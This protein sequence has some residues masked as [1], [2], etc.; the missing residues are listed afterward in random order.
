MGF[1]PSRT[2]Y[3][4][5][6]VGFA[7]AAVVLFAPGSLEDGWTIRVAMVVLAAA[8]SLGS[9]V[10]ACHVVLLALI[11]L[12]GGR[13]VTTNEPVA[14]DRSFFGVYRVT[15]RD[16]P[17]LGP[18]RSLMNGTTLHGAQAVA[19][20][21]RCRPL[22]Y[23]APSTPIGQAMSAVQARGPARIG[24]VGL[25]AGSLAAAVRPGDSL[26]FFE[27]DP[28]VVSLARSQFTYLDRVRAGSFRCCPRRRSADGR[29]R[30]GERL[31]SAGPGTPSPRTPCPRT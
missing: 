30:A 13:S 26:R 10:L 14:A 25:G 6:A 18:V 2:A 19:P 1:A 29:A 8:A 12:V 7:C 4:L 23:Y 9:G 17:G 5:L 24:V 28:L 11:A 16:V 27:I 21:L 3:A 15:V 20:A 22:T 31:R